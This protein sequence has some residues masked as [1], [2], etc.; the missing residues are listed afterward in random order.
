[1]PPPYGDQVRSFSVA[2][3]EAHRVRRRKDEALL[4][5]S[6]TVEEAVADG[7]IEIAEEETAE[8]GPGAP[9]P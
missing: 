7:K 5:L 4:K 6:T 1:L 3:G 2:A 8:A 9:G